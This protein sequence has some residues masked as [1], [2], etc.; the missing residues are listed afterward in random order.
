MLNVGTTEVSKERFEYKPI[1]PG[2]ASLFKQLAMQVTVSVRFCDI[3]LFFSK[4][5]YFERQFPSADGCL[6]L[7]FPVY[8]PTFHFLVNLKFT[9]YAMRSELVIILKQHGENS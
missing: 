7:P 3:N 2:S 4:Q 5:I 8:F 1:L 9:V 6:L